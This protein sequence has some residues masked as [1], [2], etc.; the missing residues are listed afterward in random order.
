M[1]ARTEEVE[2]PLFL[3]KFGVPFWALV[4]VFGGDPMRWYRLEVGLGRN[5]LVGT[6]VRRTEL[7]EHLLAD[8]HHT[9]RRVH[10]RGE[11][12]STTVTLLPGNLAS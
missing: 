2:G 10:F 11:G 1:T 6:T 8:E 3:R 7:P 5:S 4:R 12:C 9:R